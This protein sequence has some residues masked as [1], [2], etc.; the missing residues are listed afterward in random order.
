MFTTKVFS[1]PILYY[2]EGTVKLLRKI[3][4]SNHMSDP[5][6]FRLL[7]EAFEKFDEAIHKKHPKLKKSIYFTSMLDR[8]AR[9]IILE[10][11][12]SPKLDQYLTRC[13]HSYGK[14][15]GCVEIA[16]AGFDAKKLIF[17]YIIGSGESDW[18]LRHVL[19]GRDEDFAAQWRALITDNGKR[20][21]YD[22]Y[23]H[24]TKDGARHN[25]FPLSSHPLFKKR[26]SDQDLRALYRV[27]QGRRNGQ[28]N[29]DDI[30]AAG[31]AILLNN[32][33]LTHVTTWD[34]YFSA[35]GINSFLQ[36]QGVET[37]QV[38][39]RPQMFGPGQFDRIP[40]C[41]K[42]FTT[43]LFE[44]PSDE[45]IYDDFSLMSAARQFHSLPKWPLDLRRQDFN[46]GPVD[47]M[48]NPAFG[49][50]PHLPGSFS[51]KAALLTREPPPS[52]FRNFALWA[53]LLD[54]LIMESGGTGPELDMQKAMNGEYLQHYLAAHLT[55][56]AQQ[57]LMEKAR[58]LVPH[59][60]QDKKLEAS[61]RKLENEVI[62]EVLKGNILLTS[63]EPQ[64]AE[65]Q[66]NWNSLINYNSVYVYISGEF[67]SSAFTP[68]AHRI[69]GGVDAYVEFLVPQIFTGTLE[70]IFAD[71]G[72]P[73][74]RKIE[75]VQTLYAR[76][77]PVRDRL[78]DHLLA[79]SSLSAGEIGTIA[80]L[81]ASTALKEK[82]A[83]QALELERDRRSENFSDLDHE[84]ERV[85]NY[86]PDFSYTRDDIL[87]HI[88]NT[89]VVHPQQLPKIQNLL[90]QLPD[91]VRQEK[92][93]NKT[94]AYDVLKTIL[95][96]DSLEKRSKKN[97]LL[98]IMGFRDQKP[99][100]L[101]LLEEL[102]QVNFDSLR[103]A[104]IH[105]SKHYTDIGRSAFEDILALFLFGENGILSDPATR[106][107]FLTAIFESVVPERSN[108][109]LFKKIF[110]PVFDHAT[111]M[112]KEQ[113][114]KRLFV[115]MKKLSAEDH[116]SPNAQE[117]KAI[118]AFLESLG[119]IG[120]KVGQFLASSNLNLP[121]HILAELTK[122]KEADTSLNKAAAFRAI[123]V[124]FGSFDAIFESLNEPMA[125]PT[126]A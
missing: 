20:P 98:W 72:I 77:S 117:A 36:S 31:N 3:M 48:F 37:R 104:G 45:N 109:H 15:H 57:R 87:N 122:L 58:A 106:Q 124:A 34:E 76:P 32:S 62:K 11:T 126:S 90:L 118:R 80:G 49:F 121:P 65:S 96:N 61:N 12:A 55:F 78:L 91:N 114:L 107:E 74:S 97:L 105:D 64:S 8:F 7:K 21:F 73:C 101:T 69:P 47:A 67:D 29:S 93:R 44:I 2:G 54:E 52:I 33:W 16:Q 24:Q 116:L 99:D 13:L 115:A 100:M 50:I 81:F 110:F 70:K 108:S 123:D 75:Q 53:L 94:F 4:E 39:M 82:Y 83:L 28:F 9:E 89:R 51:E 125:M 111:E 19:F 17:L 25:H 102:Y 113:I 27:L 1:D 56:E 42:A 88:L 85:L 63:N 59:L 38:G 79:S 35:I 30:A 5:D 22:Y 43:E 84:L 68:Y 23:S 95:E 41:Y 112:R 46:D 92:V 60:I 10:A 103:G 86:F 6:K 26:F 119:F 120:T 14:S 66:K 18:G 40:S 71:P